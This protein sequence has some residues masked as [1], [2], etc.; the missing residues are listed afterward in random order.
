V[1][2][3]EIE[4]GKDEI[5]SGKTEDYGRAGRV[6]EQSTVLASQYRLQA[7]TNRQVE[8]SSKFADS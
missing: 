7:G 6:E 2:K 5:E 3:D 1:L 4:S 8:V